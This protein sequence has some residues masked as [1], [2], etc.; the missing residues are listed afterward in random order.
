M[1]CP[2]CANTESKYIF[3]VTDR[4]GLVP[5][6]FPLV[7][8]CR[9]GGQYLSP[10]PDES[11]VDPFYEEYWG[12]DGLSKS[13]AAQAELAYKNFLTWSE[14][15]RLKKWLPKGARVLDIGCGS[16]DALSFFHHWGCQCFGLEASQAG[17]NAVLNK[18]PI[19][20]QQG[21]INQHTF[22]AGQFDFILLSH[23]LEHLS[24]PHQVLQEL[25]RLLRPGGCACVMVPSISCIQRHIFKE[26]W[27]VYNPPR[28]VVYYTPQSLTCLFSQC[29]FN[30]QRI[31]HPTLKHG[32]AIL[33][34]SLFPSLEPFHIRKKSGLSGLLLRLI[35]LGLS[36]TVMPFTIFEGLIKMGSTIMVVASRSPDEHL[37]EAPKD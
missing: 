2:I 7:E 36:L 30:V 25:H 1:K 23:V 28:H 29:G 16:G 37:V 11:L 17:V 9:C 18:L 26:H 31:Y 35:Y 34:N 8:C 20:V 15:V 12:N 22:H 24:N 33:I 6:S 5:G 4:V 19:E 3:T 21:T 13:I 32:P 10:L 14:L 27:F